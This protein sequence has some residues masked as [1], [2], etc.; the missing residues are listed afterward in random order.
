ME[1]ADTM[2]GRRNRQEESVIPIRIPDPFEEM[3]RL[4]WSLDK[5]IA[6]AR[7]HMGEERWE[8]LNEEWEQ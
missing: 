3:E 4:D 7:K 5:Q 8:Q 1:Q 6:E 2:D